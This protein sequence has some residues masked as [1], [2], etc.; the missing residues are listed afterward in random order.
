MAEALA[1]IDTLFGD[2]GET[3]VVT[4]LFRGEALTP[5]GLAEM[6]ALIEEIASDQS[7]A[8][9]LTET[10]PI[11]S[12]S[13]LIRFLLGVE[14]FESVTQ[15]EIDTVRG[16]P[17][18]LNTLEAMTGTDVDGTPV[19]VV[20]IR[21]RDTGDEQIEEVERKVHGVATDFEGLLSVS[22]ISVAVVEDAYKKAT[23]EG[24]APLIG[25]PFLLMRG[26][27][28]SSCALYPTSC[29]PLSGY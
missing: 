11:I 13:I 5:G 26:S 6:D 20:T 2:S 7:V 14:S 29:S 1:K 27:S 4:L 18:I 19:A 9:L 15:E 28:C 3:N 23:E 21:L 22:S 25:L 17:E 10:D 16:P 24:M 8:Q 12:P